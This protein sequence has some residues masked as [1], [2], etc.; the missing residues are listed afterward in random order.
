V[1]A[2]ELPYGEVATSAAIAA[3]RQG[4]PLIV[5]GGGGHSFDN[6]WL[7]PP[8]SKIATIDD[9]VGKRVAYTNPK[10]ISEAFLLMLLKSRGI[11]P[12]AVTRVSAGSYGAGLTLLDNGG[13]DIAPATEPLRTMVKAKYR[14]VFTA[15]DALPPIVS[16]AMVTT[17]D[18][19]KNH[20]RELRA[21]LEGRRRGVDF[22]YAH[23]VEA[24]KITAKHYKI[25]EDVAVEAVTAM[26]KDHQWIAGELDLAEYENLA[27]GLR[28]TGEL[29]GE[30]DW[31]S[32]ID[33]S[34]L[35]A[36]LQSM[37]KLDV[38]R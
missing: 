10:S 12:G 7:V 2:S 29:S 31:K 3:Q 30:V 15:K 8:S 24:G 27:D 13:V 34:Y 19:A 28:L 4:L 35:P 26:A 37:S 6:A 38:R 33:L 11:D 9:L 25:A 14:V 36:D 1:L 16:T 22:I 32:L 21:L 20:A 23:P 5:L 18:Y 17:R